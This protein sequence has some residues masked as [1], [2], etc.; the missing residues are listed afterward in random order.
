[1]VFYFMEIKKKNLIQCLM[2]IVLVGW[3]SYLTFGSERASGNSGGVILAAMGTLITFLVGWQI[4]NT[5]IS[6]E[7]LKNFEEAYG[8][9]IN[10]LES[11]L[12]DLNQKYDKS[13]SELKTHLDE[14]IWQETYFSLIGFE[15]LKDPK[16]PDWLKNVFL[17]YNHPFSYSLRTH[18]RHLLISWL[19][20]ISKENDYTKI[21]SIA[22]QISKEDIDKL[23]NEIMTDEIMA[24]CDYPDIISTLNKIKAECQY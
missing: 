8:Q 1:M 18:S 17:F 15:A 12:N 14:K 6:K 5:I 10:M 13:V 20:D 21:K 11:A 23:Y 19:K 4:Y 22:S 3:L 7:Q 9:R 2:I 16:S 24:D